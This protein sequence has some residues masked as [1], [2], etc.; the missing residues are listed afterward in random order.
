MYDNGRGVPEDDVEAVRWYR[1]APD[2]GDAGA[3]H[4]LGVMY[5]DGVGVP[6]DMVLAYMWWNLSAAQGH[7]GAR[8]RNLWN[9]TEPS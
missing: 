1:L 8:R 3:Q 4:N 2:Q 6:E 9:V 5:R 7:E